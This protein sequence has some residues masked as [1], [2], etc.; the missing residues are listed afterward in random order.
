MRGVLLVVH[1]AAGSG[2]LLLGALAL[3]LPKRPG[4]H[5]GVAL[6]YLMA[7]TAVC[8]TA[9]G[10]AVLRPALWWLSIIAVAT[11]AAALA[12]YLLAE[13]RPHRWAGRSVRLLSMSYVSL[14]TAVLVV[15]VPVPVL[16][17]GADPC[18]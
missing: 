16:W 2:G 5:R 7:A 15:S 17:A 14:V 18:R 10:L 1:I 9:I 4:W 12:G 11:Q 13:R 3:G 6:A 8:V